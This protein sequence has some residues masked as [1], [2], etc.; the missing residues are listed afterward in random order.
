MCTHRSARFLTHLF[1][2][3]QELDIQYTVGL[4]TDVN[5][6]YYFIGFDNQDGDLDGF[7]DEANV[8]L[9]LDTPPQVLTTSYGFS[10]SDLSFSL[11]E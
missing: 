7:L 6:T 3:P 2:P 10:E 9:G 11:V 5:V 4:A 8:L 1:A